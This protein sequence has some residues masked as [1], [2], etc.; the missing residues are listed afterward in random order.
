[1]L[2]RDARNWVTRPE[3]DAGRWPVLTTDEH[4]R[5]KELER[6][7]RERE[8]ANELLR[9]ASAYFAQAQTGRR[10]DVITAFLDEP[11]YVYETLPICDVPPIA[12]ST[13]SAAKA[14]DT[15][16]ALRS[17]ESKRDTW[18]RGG[19][20]AGLGRRTSDLWRP[21]DLAGAEP[22]IE[23]A[24]CNG[25]APRCRPM[26]ESGRWTW[27]SGISRRRARIRCGDRT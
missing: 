16:Q 20:R 21:E 10:A 8:G 25:F 14:R 15:D 4:K 5:L 18:L 26:L 6:E 23:V 2:R 12:P 13:Y 22:R 27:W 1:M 11:R 24:R 19:D 7:N 3:R 17:E 9:K